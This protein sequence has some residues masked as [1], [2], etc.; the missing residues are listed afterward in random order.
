MVQLLIL[1]EYDALLQVYHHMF[2]EAVENAL[3]KLNPK[4]NTA[5]RIRYG[6]YGEVTIF[7]DI[8]KLFGVTP[9]RAG[10]IVSKALWKLRRPLNA[11]KLKEFNE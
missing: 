11:R 9:E 5:V 6:F 7:K 10:Q 3:Q 1:D 8:G 4:E 2:K